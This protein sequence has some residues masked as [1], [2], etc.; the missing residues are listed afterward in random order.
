M[1]VMAGMS[2]AVAARIRRLMH[3]AIAPPRA[4]CHAKK[5]PRD[6]PGRSYWTDLAVSRRSAAVAEQTQQ[7]QEHVD[8]VEVE[9]ERAHHG[10]ASRDGAVVHRVVHFLDL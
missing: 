1:A 8:E 7:E 3:H 9:R 6:D 10:L 5:A 4:A 2:A